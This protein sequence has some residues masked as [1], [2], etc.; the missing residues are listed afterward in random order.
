MAF[1]QEFT[2]VDF[3]P[4]A[5][6][7]WGRK[8]TLLGDPDHP[9]TLAKNAAA[10]TGGGVASQF[11]AEALKGFHGGGGGP[12][13]GPGDPGGTPSGPSFGTTPTINFNAP[14]A[15]SAAMGLLG[16]AITGNPLGLLGALFSGTTIGSRPNDATIAFGKQPTFRDLAQMVA[17]AQKDVQV[18]QA[19]QQ[20]QQDQA[21]E[22]ISLFGQN[23]GIDPG[24]FGGPGPGFGPTSPGIGPVGPDGGIGLDA[25]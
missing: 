6:P 10:N 21:R 24:G 4:N 13:G 12:S 3:D 25:L 2:P 8:F 1:P 11:I 18:A 22:A 17:G 7:F 5:D 23:L 15:G 14:T 19:D 16:S 9:L 20:A